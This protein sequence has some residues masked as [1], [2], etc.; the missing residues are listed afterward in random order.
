MNLGESFPADD[1]SPLEWVLVVEYCANKDGR[2]GDDRDVDEDDEAND[3]FVDFRLLTI[4]WLLVG[5]V[6]VE[7]FA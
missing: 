1:M 3:E 2:I 5:L 6:V 4:V 7:E